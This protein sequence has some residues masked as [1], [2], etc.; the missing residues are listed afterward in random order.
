MWPGPIL[1]CPLRDGPAQSSTPSTS[2]ARPGHHLRSTRP[3][4]SRRGS[5]R[6]S[7]AQ[8]CPAAPGLSPQRSLLHDDNE[9]DPP[10]RPP[11][12]SHP[13][14]S[15]RVLFAFHRAGSLGTDSGSPTLARPLLSRERP[16]RV[17]PSAASGLCPRPGAPSSPARP[18]PARTRGP[19]PSPQPHAVSSRVKSIHSRVPWQP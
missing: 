1:H 7:R 15:G 18:Y 6:F 10:Q 13:G 5:R 11:E 9:A 3:G 16:E 19:G 4:R 14:R 2:A 8:G 12:L 17:R